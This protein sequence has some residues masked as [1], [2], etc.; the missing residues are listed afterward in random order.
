[1]LANPMDADAQHPKRT[2]HMIELLGL[3]YR[4]A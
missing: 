2:L 4:D 3:A 1:M